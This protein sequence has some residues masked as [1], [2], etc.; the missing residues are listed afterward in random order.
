[1]LHCLFFNGKRRWWALL[2]SLIAI[3][4]RSQTID[5]S[6]VIS[7]Q[8]K[9]RFEVLEKRLRKLSRKEISGLNEVVDFSVSGV[10]I[11]EFLRGLA[12]SNNLNISVDP[13]LSIRVVNNFNNERV[14]NI[15]LF[16]CKEYDLD[17]RFVGSI[18]SFYK[19]TTVPV[20]VVPPR[21]EIAVMYNSYNDGLS[22]DLQNDSLTRV[23]RKITQL[24]KKNIVLAHGLE[25]HLVSAYLE[26]MPFETALDKMAYAN[27]LKMVKTSDN[28][29]VLKPSSD[30]LNAGQQNQANN[31]YGNVGMH[32]APSVGRFDFDIQNDTAGQKITIDA[33]NTPVS[34]LIKSIS[35]EAKVNYFMFSEPKG[36]TT[37]KVSSLSYQETLNFLLQGTEHTFKQENG[38]YLI[39]E[40]S[41]EGLRNTKVLQLQ[42]RSA[43]III[44][45]IPAELKKGVDVKY[46]KELNSLIL[47]GSS[48]RIQEIEAF[49]K[50]VDKVVPVIHIEVILVNVSKSHTVKT[51]ISAGLDST[52]KRTGGSIFPG[53]NFTFNSASINSL[54]G[55]LQTSNIFNLGRVT[56]NFYVNLSALEENG[57]VNIQSTPKLST[58][59]GHEAS[60]KI[61]SKIY[62]SLTTQNTLGTLTPSVISTVQYNQVEANLTIK[63]VPTVSG[64]EQV[65]LEIDVDNTDFT[66]TTEPGPPP[67]TTAAF[68]S[69]IRIKNEEMIVLGGLERFMKSDKGSGVP[70]LSRIPVIKWLFSNRTKTRSKTKQL[71][72]IRP[73]IIY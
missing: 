16:L 35:Q 66:T 55:Q 67:T 49:V 57:D 47:S 15:L 60:L 52:A 11:Q 50:Q 45:N 53:F 63:I 58:L 10:S 22:L 6:D 26:N 42:N 68:K 29:Y 5:T 36:N 61:G 24:S 17:I 14:I 3:A 2:F 69:L 39:G 59:N 30:H 23:A 9:D 8:E 31:G 70:L 34:D 19:H 73:T 32:P 4:G 1:M 64:D 33:L 27:R 71:V 51:G 18:M 44:E 40:R 43:E 65:T 25:G 56:P 46:F 54:L 12:E 41:L 62:Y 48:P 38:I 37:A 13:M 28:F 21:K 7:G 20:V 72:F